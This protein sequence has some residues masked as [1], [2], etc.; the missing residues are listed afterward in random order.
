MQSFTY[1]FPPPLQLAN[2]RGRVI[3]MTLGTLCFSKGK[4]YVVPK[5]IFFFQCTPPCEL[6][7]LSYDNNVN[8]DDNNNN[9]NNNDSN[10]KNSNNND[11]NNNNNYISTML[12]TI[13]TQSHSEFCSFTTVHRGHSKNLH[14]SCFNV[15]LKPTYTLNES[16][17]IN[18]NSQIAGDIESEDGTPFLERPPSRAQVPVLRSYSTDK[19]PVS[20]L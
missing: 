18:V 4:K 20:P 3:I 1:V 15:N 16:V 2:A 9:N 13:T 17:T 5:L 7:Y 6:K 10:T 12:Q 14:S 8:S 11:N 19:I